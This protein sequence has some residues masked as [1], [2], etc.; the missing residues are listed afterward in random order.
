MTITVTEGGDARK[1]GAQRQELIRDLPKKKNKKGSNKMAKLRKKYT[2]RRRM[3]PRT[4]DEAKRRLV[5][6]WL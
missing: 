4:W 1:V 5:A 2:T 3:G 6:R